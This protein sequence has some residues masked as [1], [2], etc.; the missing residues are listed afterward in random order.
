MHRLVGDYFFQDMRWRGPVDRLY[1]QESAIEPGVEE[2]VKIG[3]DFF[4]L[5]F[6]AHC[7]EQV[8]AH[9]DQAPGSA[10]GEIDTP[11]QFLPTRFGCG[12]YA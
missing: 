7:R 11:Q 12:G 8:F 6:F 9:L 10:G 5:G 1:Q 4:Q 2:V 3:V